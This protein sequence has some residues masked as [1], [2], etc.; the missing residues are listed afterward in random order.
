VE[1]AWA[2]REASMRLAQAISR[3]SAERERQKKE[4]GRNM[5][6]RIAKEY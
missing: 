6:G 1:G 4:R 3:S 2:Q 5:G